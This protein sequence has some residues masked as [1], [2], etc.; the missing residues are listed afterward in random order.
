MT[1][2]SRS[3]LRLQIGTRLRWMGTRW[4]RI[5][6][7][8]KPI[9]GDRQQSAAHERTLSL[10]QAPWGQPVIVPDRQQCQHASRERAMHRQVRAQDTVPVLDGAAGPN[11]PIPGG[12]QPCC[13]GSPVGWDAF[14]QLLAGGTQDGSSLPCPAKPSA[15]PLAPTAHRRG[16][17]THPVLEQRAPAASSLVSNFFSSCCMPSGAV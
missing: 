12:Q 16:P 3:Q 17:A 15:R 4:W 14:Q 5:A 13:Q 9:V 7:G 2:S 1:L 10:M 8:L 11:G 6:Q